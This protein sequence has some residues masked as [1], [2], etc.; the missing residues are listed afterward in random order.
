MELVQQKECP[1]GGESR[2]F[3]A[4]E[5]WMI[6]RNTK[7]VGSSKTGDISIRFVSRDILRPG[8]CRFEKPLVTHPVQAAVFRDL[9]FMNGK[10]RC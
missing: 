6:F 9:E 5:K 3:V 10:H 8:E 4:V 1:C 7:S 2:A